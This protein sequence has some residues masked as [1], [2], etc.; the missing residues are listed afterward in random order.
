MSTRGENYVV[1]E[2]EIKAI[3][4][5]AVLIAQNDIEAWIPRSL[6][7]GGTDCML[8]KDVIHTEM[9]VKM[10]MWKADQEGF[11]YR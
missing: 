9:A 3:S 8:H 5:R 1:V 7:H 10:F 11:Q 4:P 2:C 6:L